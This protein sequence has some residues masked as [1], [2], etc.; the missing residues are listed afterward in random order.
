[1]ENPSYENENIERKYLK[2]MWK[3][4]FLKVKN[5]ALKL[6]K[7]FVEL[8]DRELK[9]RKVKIKKEIWN[10][11]SKPIIVSID[12]KDKFEKKKKIEEN[13]AN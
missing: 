7:D 13:K 4:Q 8:K 6:K 3:N 11:F 10:L 12:D 9:H 2:N 5:S 1:M